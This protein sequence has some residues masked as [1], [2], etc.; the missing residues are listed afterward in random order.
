M[1]I[2]LLSGGSG[3]RL[4]PLS[5]DARAKQFVPFFKDRDGRYESM[6]QR[7]YR[8]LKKISPDAN[9]V[10][11]SG[12]DQ[13]PLLKEQLGENIDISIEPSRKDTYPAIVL[14]CAY[15]RDVLK[16]DQNETVI[17]CPVDPYVEDSYFKAIKELS[18]IIEKDEAKISLIGVKPTEPTSKYG[19]IMPKDEKKISKVIGFREKPDFDKAKEYIRQGG[20]WN[21]AIMGFR[22]NYLLDKAEKKLNFKDY[23]SFL[24][25]YSLLNKSNISYDLLEKE[26]DI[27]VLTFEGIWDDLGSWDTFIKLMDEDTY[28]QGVIRNSYNTKVVNETDIPVVV[29]YIDNANIIISKN[30]IYITR[31]DKSDDIKEILSSLEKK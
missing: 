9:I 28:G 30:G 25:G 21:T 27:Q 18:E 2:I 7:M 3:R 17:V 22:L 5:H 6:I 20:L 13:V 31:N 26:E 10:I 19:Y 14:A 11:A 4:W 15:L 8:S 24:Q 1:N 23:D 29:N 12:V 16:V